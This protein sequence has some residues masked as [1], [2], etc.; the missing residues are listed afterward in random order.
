MVVKIY[1]DNLDSLVQNANRLG[2]IIETVKG[3]QNLY[4]EPVSGLPQVVVKYNR[5][6]LY[7][8]RCV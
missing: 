2:K 5:F 3:T 6:L 8:S 1:G 7:T 4:I